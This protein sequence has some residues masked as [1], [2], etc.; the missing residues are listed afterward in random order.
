M[1]NDELRQLELFS[2]PN[3]KGRNASKKRVSDSLRGFMT[4]YEKTVL[5]IISFI[6]SGVISFSLG[7]ERGKKIA[8]LKLNSH[9]D[10]ATK[11][12]PPKIQPPEDN[13]KIIPAQNYPS[14]PELAAQNYTIQVATYKK[15]THAHQEASV[16]RKKGFSTT[17]MSKGVHI[18]VCV[19]NFSDK[20]TA[21]SLLTQLK[22]RYHDCFIRRL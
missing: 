5:I 8:N 1:A 18:I 15:K 2:Q 17:V 12:Q 10:M 19:G 3:V 6:V 22:K 21:K 20:E 13:Q 16:L 9:F 7:V 4:H 14:S 11:I